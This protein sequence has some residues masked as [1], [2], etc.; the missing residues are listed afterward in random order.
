MSR[1]GL[2]ET[3]SRIQIADLPKSLA[4]LKQPAK[5]TA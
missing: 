5:A 4:E 2:A 3:G 1:V